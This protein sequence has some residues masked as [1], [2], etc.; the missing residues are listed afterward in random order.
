[1]LYIFLMVAFFCGS[2]CAMEE[3]DLVFRTQGR[4]LGLGY[5]RKNG[6]PSE[7]IDLIE[8]KEGNYNNLNQQLLDE[9]ADDTI[10]KN[11]KRVAIHEYVF[12]TKKRKNKIIK[13]K[14]TYV[15]DKKY[16][17]V[18]ELLAKKADVNF[19]RTSE[20]NKD[21]IINTPLFAAMQKIV[22]PNVIQL[23]LDKGA[24]PNVLK[25]E[26]KKFKSSKSAL[27]QLAD[28]VV[29][30]AAQSSTP[31]IS[32]FADL[33][34]E[35]NYLQDA[36]NL[37]IDRVSNIN[38]QGF[39]GRTFAHQMLCD[40]F[41]PRARIFFVQNILPNEKF[42]KEFDW[43]LQDNDGATILD[44][45]RT[46]DVPAILGKEPTVLREAES[47]KEIRT[48]Y[49]Q[50]SFVNKQPPLDAHKSRDRIIGG[51]Q[52]ACDAI[53]NDLIDFS[54]QNYK[55][56]TALHAMMS[57][58][59]MSNEGFDHQNDPKKFE[60]ILDLTFNNSDYVF[61]VR[62]L[63][64]KSDINK[65]NKAGKT[66]LK[67]AIEKKNLFGALYLL[68][69]DAQL[70]G[71]DAEDLAR[72]FYGYGSNFSINYEFLKSINVADIQTDRAHLKNML[73]KNME[74]F[75]VLSPKKDGDWFSSF[76][77]YFGSTPKP[78][79]NAVSSNANKA[80][81][82]SISEKVLQG[83]G[84]LDHQVDAKEPYKPT[85]NDASFTYRIGSFIQMPF[86]YIY[87][88]MHNF[89]YSAEVVRDY[90]QDDRIPHR[91][92]LYQFMLGAASSP[93]IALKSYCSALKKRI[94]ENIVK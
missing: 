87:T 76:T 12:E 44:F 85:V 89:F 23:L 15:Q 17:I 32:N 6:S 64:Q 10:E 55:G 22:F 53:Q 2:I 35:L 79:E 41:S 28:R 21:E 3:D 88:K 90:K 72:M 57:G 68:F 61:A 47:K 26:G 29:I 63:I 71:K 8:L 40:K 83:E 45:L 43:T 73:A 36:F 60:E 58:V 56:D 84:Q 74:H 54:W 77:S 52:K 93:F 30:I 86:L 37:L 94:I 42:N 14:L 48:I 20:T 18:C 24:N 50:Q 19:C 16:N 78:E 70:D 31:G 59:P 75:S 66:P 38:E 65:K 82:A 25:S 67:L 13:Q 69:Y 1:M 80:V 9:L 39:Y 62:K 92:K 4:G 51:V 49:F 33:F 27:M 91:T 7:Q 34:W 81:D 5:E 11:G 46:V